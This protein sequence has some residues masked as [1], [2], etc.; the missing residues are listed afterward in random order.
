[1][2]RNVL[3]ESYT[4]RPGL[5]DRKGVE[6][7]TKVEGLRNFAAFPASTSLEQI[8]LNLISPNAEYVLALEEVRILKIYALS[9]VYRAL[10]EEPRGDLPLGNLAGDV[11]FQLLQAGS[12]LLEIKDLAVDHV[13]ALG[14]DGSVIKVIDSA[15]EGKKLAMILIPKKV[16]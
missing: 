11:P 5:T 9:R 15:R 12:S 3:T 14:A 4:G 2:G 6:M 1:M 10:L 7:E 13:L 8:E 16:C